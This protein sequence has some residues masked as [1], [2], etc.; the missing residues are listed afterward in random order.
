MAR[1]KSKK[2]TPT[3]SLDELIEF[4]DTHDMGDVWEQ[5]PS[6]RFDVNIKS[7]THLVAIDEELANQLTEIAKSRR[8]S[9][10]SLINSWLRERISN[11]EDAR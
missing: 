3:E 10:E 5:M 4:F 2:L 9:S 11:R 8:T 1:S 7:R 6:V